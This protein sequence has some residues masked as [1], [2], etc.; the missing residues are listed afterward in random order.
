MELT[1]EVKSW[2]EGRNLVERNP[3]DVISTKFKF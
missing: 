3:L 2:N 1:W